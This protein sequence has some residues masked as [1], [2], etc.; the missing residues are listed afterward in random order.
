MTYAMSTSTLV[1][2]AFLI[3]IVTLVTPLSAQTVSTEVS[4]LVKDPSG[5]ATAGAEVTL[6]RLATGESRRALSNSEGIYAFPLI[7]P[8]EYR[9]VV[10]MPG[11][12]TTTVSN[13]NVLYQQRARVDVTLEIGELNQRV[14]VAAEAR[15]LNTEDAAVGQNIESTRIV[16]LPVAYR[17]VGQLALLVPGVSFGTRMGRA[18]GSD[19]G[20]HARRRRHQGASL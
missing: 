7:E 13:I 5:A 15:L 9:V 6:T 4:G 20:A 17:S 10:S 19:A 3:A 12:K 11:F 16:E 8:G 1:R 14:E 18:T 2:I